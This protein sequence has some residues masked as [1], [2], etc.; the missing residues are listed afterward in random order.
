MITELE[1]NKQ[2]VV[3]W[4]EEAGDTAEITATRQDELRAGFRRFPTF[5]DELRPTME[6]L[7]H[8]ADEQTP[9]LTDL[10]R[11]A[12]DLNTF[13]ERVGPF[14]EASRPAIDSLGE[15][16]AV[17]TRAFKEGR[18]EIAEL[19]ELADDAQPFAKP[20]R[21]FLETIDDRKRAIEDGPAREGNRA[22][23]AGP[24]GDRGL[25]AASPAWR[26]SGTTSTGRPSASTC[27]TTR[28][29]C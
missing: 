29:T 10:Q 4:V 2:D 18:E 24:D 27:S 26:R 5:L 8:L 9:L 23:G 21:Q 6:R 13:F 20:L 15:A 14:S 11:A 12:P 19:R 7:G 25:A 22:A 17:G 3:R 1:R 28:A 16:A